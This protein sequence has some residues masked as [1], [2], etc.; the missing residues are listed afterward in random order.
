MIDAVILFFLLGLFA[1]ALR[2]ELKLPSVLYESLS[3]FLMLTI[4]LKGGKE[5]AMQSLHS[6]WPSIV[7]VIALCIGLTLLAYSA[8][9][10]VFRL[11]SVNAAATSAH[12]GSVSI[13][14]F[15]VG[16]TWLSSRGI[17]SEPQMPVLLAVMEIPA[18]TVGLILAK[19]VKARSQWSLLAK[20]V[21]LGKSVTL[22]LGGMAIG[23]VAGPEGL[24]SISGVYFDSFKGVLAL[25]LLEMGLIVSRQ[26]HEIK[27]RALMLISFGIIMPLVSASLGL[28]T[29]KLLGF[30]IGGM[31]LLATLAASA[32]YIAVP[33]AMRVT[34]PQANPALSLA[35]ALGVT[36]P[37]NLL[38]GIPLYH[39]AATF[40]V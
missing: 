21:F 15:A 12:Y 19:G 38:L 31:T 29:A 3:I 8:L 32:S 9:R 18:I 35:A 26:L 4:G 23:W 5:L 16:L 1:G 10:Y 20:D 28:L 25:F 30:S 37:F 40:M 17:S 39:W 24:H 27:R 34:L 2:S 33:A 6:L 7:A 13:A 11:D 22:L 14:T 36:F